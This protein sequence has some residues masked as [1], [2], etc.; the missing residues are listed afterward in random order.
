MA[1]LRLERIS[2]GLKL[3]TVAVAV[4]RTP[5]WLSLIERDKIPVSPSMRRLIRKAI[6]QE[7]R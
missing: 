3:E 2:A 4:N 5:A 6:K 7:S 1:N